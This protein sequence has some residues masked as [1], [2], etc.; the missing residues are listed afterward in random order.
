LEHIVGWFDK[1]LQGISKAE[2]DEVAAPQT[3]VKT[4]ESQGHR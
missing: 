1:Y 3:G 2:Y 4:E